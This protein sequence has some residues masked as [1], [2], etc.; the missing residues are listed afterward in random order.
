MG[1]GLKPA[2]LSVPR[3]EVPGGSLSLPWISKDGKGLAPGDYAGPLAVSPWV[4]LAC[5]DSITAGWRGRMWP[6]G[7]AWPP[8]AVSA[9]GRQFPQPELTGRWDAPFWAMQSHHVELVRHVTAGTGLPA[10]VLNQ[11][12]AGATTASYLDRL[13]EP[14]FQ[15]AVAACR[16]AFALVC[17]GTNDAQPGAPAGGDNLA[18]LVAGLGNAGLRPEAIWLAV[19]PVPGGS[20]VWAPVVAEVCVRTGC[21]PGP[22]FS[23]LPSRP[24]WMADDRHPSEAGHSEMAARWAR[25]LGIPEPSP[26][27]PGHFVD[28]FDIPGAAL[29][30]P[31]QANPGSLWSVAS[32]EAVGQLGTFSAYAT[33]AGLEG[34]TQRVCGT[35]IGASGKV[36]A[37]LLRYQDPQN[38]YAAV[39]A[40]GGSSYVALLRFAGGYQTTLAS[41][42]LSNP[43]AGVPFTLEGRADG[44]TLRLLIGGQ[45]WLTA[46]L[47]TPGGPGVGMSVSPGGRVVGFSADVEP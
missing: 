45:E 12:W 47:T 37:C 35:F 14:G 22:D 6:P 31:W 7:A 18:L 29:Q 34:P 43:V 21:R 46:Q 32:G 2:L 23:D 17:L 3:P 28:T 24:E 13:R 25:S 42:A 36:W 4:G 10:F 44:L 26:P 8:D 5:G 41:R 20:R 33:V 16:P 9:D 11:G 30:P 19:P 40:S 15:D 1:N 38:Y 27:A 39:R